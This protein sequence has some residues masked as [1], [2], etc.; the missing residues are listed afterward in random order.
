MLE[1]ST[2]VVSAFAMNPTAQGGEVKGFLGFMV[3][4][5]LLPFAPKVESKTRKP[6]GQKRKN[7]YT[8]PRKDQLESFKKLL[9][10]IASRYNEGELYQLYT[11]MHQMAKLLLDIYRFRH[12]L[13]P[14]P[15]EDLR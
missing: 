9:G 8:R 10:P 1:L 13:K 11:E 6:M 3:G 5:A 12:N 4:S 2:S 14:D 15:E 7:R